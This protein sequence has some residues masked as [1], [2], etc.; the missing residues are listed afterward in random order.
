MVLGRSHSSDSLEISGANGRH[1]ACTELLLSPADRMTTAASSAA[2]AAALTVDLATAVAGSTSANQPLNTGVLVELSQSGDSTGEGRHLSHQ[3]QWM[4]PEMAATIRTIHNNK[5]ATIRQHY[6][7]EGN[8]IHHFFK[9]RKLASL[10]HLFGGIMRQIIRW[11]GLGD[12]CYHGI[13]PV[14]QPRSPVDCGRFTSL[15]NSS[16]QHRQH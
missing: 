10:F 1:L 16:D 3:F 14:H 13:G 12:C 5:K 15:A 9:K 11:L 7:P 6:Y 8:N 4:R 2:V